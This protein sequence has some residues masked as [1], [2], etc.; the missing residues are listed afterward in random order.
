MSEQEIE[1]LRQNYK[2]LDEKVDLIMTNHLP[3]I[4]VSL[5]V[6][7]SRLGTIMWVGGI[8]GSTAILAL[9]GAFF[10]LILK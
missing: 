7:S 9:V 10:K 8:V 5:E 3:H 4:Q 1:N 2:N 6:M